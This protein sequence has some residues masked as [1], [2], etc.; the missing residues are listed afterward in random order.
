M[1]TN[2]TFNGRS[3][4]RTHRQIFR[5]QRNSPP[6]FLNDDDFHGRKRINGTMSGEEERGNLETLKLIRIGGFLNPNVTMAITLYRR[7][8]YLGEK[9][10]TVD[11]ER[12]VETVR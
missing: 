4:R 9:K 6:K 5:H 2:I 8:D 7:K 12:S 1:K 10:S 3:G 11:I